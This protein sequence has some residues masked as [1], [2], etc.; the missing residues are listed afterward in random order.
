MLSDKYLYYSNDRLKMLAGSEIS[1][2]DEVFAMSF[3]IDEDTGILHI[4][5]RG[6]EE[7]MLESVVDAMSKFLDNYSVADNFK[8]QLLSIR[9]PAADYIFMLEQAPS[10]VSYLL[11]KGYNESTIINIVTRIT[12]EN[13]NSMK[14]LWN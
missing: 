9:K 13:F 10:V 7:N 2:N 14:G 1:E 8:V 3:Q 11:A 12:R 6:Y 5:D 4:N